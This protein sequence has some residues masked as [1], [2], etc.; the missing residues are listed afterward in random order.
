MKKLTLNEQIFLIAIWHLKDD[1][2]GVQ[3]HKKISEMTGNSMLY[4]SLYNSLEN[5]VKKGYV[6]VKKGEPTTERG[7]NNKVY[8]FLTD[9]GRLAL[10]NAKELQKTI[11]E[12]MPDTIFEGTL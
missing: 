1:A 7:G 5:L 6:L 4:G 9:A 8:Y 11:W 2:Y 10:Q 3:I 12:N